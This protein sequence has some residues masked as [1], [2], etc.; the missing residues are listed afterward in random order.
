M[1]DKLGETLLRKV[2][3]AWAEE[4]RREGRETGEWNDSDSEDGNYEVDSD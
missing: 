2:S 3:L 4:A 1:L